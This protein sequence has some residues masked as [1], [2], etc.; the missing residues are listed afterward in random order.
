MLMNEASV[1]IGIDVSK[2]ALDVHIL[3]SG[4]RQSVENSEAGIA[5]LVKRLRTFGPAALVVLEATNRYWQAVATALGAAGLRVAVVNP[6]QVRDFAKA[7]GVLAKTDRIDAQVLAWFAERI[8]PP[9][10]P[11]PGAECQTA[12]ELLS[13]RTQVMGMLVAEKNRLASAGAA[14]VRKDIQ[15]TIAFLEKRLAR[16]EGD[17]DHWLSQTPLDQT[18]VNLMATFTGIGQNTARSLAIT[19]PELGTLSHKQIGALGGLAP[20]AR[21]SGAKRGQRHIHGGRAQVRACLYMPTLTAIRCNPV[22]RAFY[23]RLTQAGKH[24]YVAIT[25]CMRK[26]LVI[27]NAMLKSGQPWTPPH[28]A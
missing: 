26:I 18:R 24:H 21:D 13:R 12:A 11:L 14:K 8:R 19:L 4:E 5:E 25:A 10:R 7:L 23:Q 15:T 22:I 1:F 20:L 2:G 9:V 16:L 27:L 17:I 6:R 3:P 28:Q